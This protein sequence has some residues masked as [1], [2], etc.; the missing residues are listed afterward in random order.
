MLSRWTQSTPR[1]FESPAGRHTDRNGSRV[2]ARIA[3]G[4]SVSSTKEE[5][6]MSFL[7][8]LIIGLVVGA[9]AKLLMPGKDP[10]GIVVT[11]LLGVAGSLI[12]GWVGRAFGWWSSGSHGVGIIASIVG[13]M[14]L[15]GIYRVYLRSRGQVHP[16]AQSSV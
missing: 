5:V 16:P 11:M 13:A 12:A 3:P 8:M 2:R 14:L 4:P 6:M 1:P 9:I 15:L 7:W 10:G